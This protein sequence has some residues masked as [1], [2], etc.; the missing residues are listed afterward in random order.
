MVTG[1]PVA[2]QA[3]G[4]RPRIAIC[5]YLVTRQ[6]PIGSC[7]LALLEQLCE[8][9][10]FVVF[11]TGFN[12]PRPDRIGY[13][14]VPAVTRP[15]AL[16]FLTYH[17]A[18]LPV[19]F[20]AKWVRGM[21]FDVVQ[22]TETYILLGDVFYAHF[23]HKQYLREHWPSAQGRG[24]N[25]ISR[26]LDHALRSSIEAPLYRNAKALVV[27]S[28][29]LERELTQTYG[30]RSDRIEVIGNP[31]DIVGFVQPGSFDREAARQQM[32]VQPGDLLAVFVALGH[33]ERKG[34]PHILAAMR[35]ARLRGLKL[36]IV[37][38]R[39]GLIEEYRTRA[40]DLGIADDVILMGLQ[41][42]V[43][44]Y[45][46]ASDLFLFPSKYE[47]FSL[48]TLQ[49]AAAGLPLV[50]TRINGSEEFLE[51]G[52]NG[53]VIES[54]DRGVAEGLERFV[55]LSVEERR[56]MG[57]NARASVERFSRENFGRRWA[58]FY[59]RILTSKRASQQ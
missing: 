43:R 23:C 40:R 46:W 21:R 42:D 22:G 12:N 58:G 25:R 6:T 13:V 51:D 11:A 57:R 19:F 7:Y 56:S 39:E 3:R 45:F 47:V 27:P 4:A 37:G 55:R 15:L 1:E 30:L 24:L 9:F 17:V 16:L 50:T 59:R 33:F 41:D 36:L 29:G 44:P 26:W 8:E 32:G 38:A 54:S 31:V 5:D 20:W 34:L 53:F 2:T 14:H 10:D 48:V 18:F 52:T 35:K 49:A 28:K